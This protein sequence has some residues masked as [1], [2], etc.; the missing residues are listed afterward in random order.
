MEPIP[1]F[2]LPEEDFTCIP[3]RTF[4]SALLAKFILKPRLEKLSYP[5]FTTLQVAKM[6]SKEPPT[7]E[8]L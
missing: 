3:L 1:H 2:A 4:P 6:M 5:D 7:V 8:Y